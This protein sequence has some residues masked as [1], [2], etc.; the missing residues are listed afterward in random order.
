MREVYQQI[1]R[2]TEAV[3]WAPPRTRVSLGKARLLWIV[4]R[5]GLVD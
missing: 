4:M 5:H 1:L 3:G 2:E